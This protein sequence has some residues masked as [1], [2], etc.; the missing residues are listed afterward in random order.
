VGIRRS[1]RPWLAAA[2]VIT[3]ATA[4]AVPATLGR[5]A[6]V[7]PSL[8]LL[9]G[10]KH[11]TAERFG[12]D[13]PSLFLPPSVYVAAT[14]GTFEIDA[15]RHHGGLDLEQVRRA[16][17][18]VAPIRHIRLSGGPASFSDG[19]PRFFSVTLTSSDGTV[20]DH[21]LPSFCPAED[22]ETQRVATSGA[23][24]PTFP[25]E[26][27]D[28][29]TKATVW[30]IDDGWAVAP[31]FSLSADPA[32]APDGAYTLTVAV[33]PPYAHQLGIAARDRKVSISV[34]IKTRAGGGCTDVCP[35]QRRRQAQLSGA[36]RHRLR[37][38]A[39]P[40]RAQ[41]NNGGLPD[42]AALPAHGLSVSHNDQS[43][44]DF[45]NFGATIWNAGPGTFDVEGFRKG[46]RPTMRARQYIYRNGHSV[47]SMNI[48]KFEF[49]NRAGHH[50]WHLEDVARYDLLNSSGKRVVLSHKQSF[51]LAPTNAVNLTA[52][53]ALWNPY[54]IGLESSC[55]TDQSLWLRET[56]PVGWGDTY[57]QRKG[58]QAFNITNVPNGRY[59]IRVTTN[60]FG[61]I[62]ETTRKNDRALVTV[63]I[64]GT[65]GDRTVTKLGK[66]T[67]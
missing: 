49:D 23:D 13:D 60:P 24:N 38:T 58:G 2:A 19:I 52:P 47:Q 14:H 36:G 46:G 33:T 15:K 4:I 50:H 18:K 22:F 56:L 64:G 55:P 27:G 45:L 63:Q 6:A 25:Q 66:P 17:S 51:C 21:S 30:G 44:N 37:G 62:H 48:G 39:L 57:I 53:G 42:L 12:S 61:N 26:C 10:P 35:A 65:P 31:F 59:E 9:T 1:R 34:N 67:K 54:S 41:N 29:L 11:V 43:G 5:A 7:K 40:D 28:S 16:G 8:R 3:A 32:T 20:V